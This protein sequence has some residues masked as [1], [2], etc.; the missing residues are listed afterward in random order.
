LFHRA[1]SNCEKLQKPEKL[2]IP[3]D[4]VAAMSSAAATPI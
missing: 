3:S 1:F 4:F 2:Q